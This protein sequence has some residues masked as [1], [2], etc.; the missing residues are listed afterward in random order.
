MEGQEPAVILQEDHFPEPDVRRP[1]RGCACGS[2]LACSYLFDE[3]ADQERWGGGAGGCPGVVGWPRRHRGACQCS[4]AASQSTACRPR[5]SMLFAFCVIPEYLV[6][7][8]HQVRKVSR[9]DV[10][11]IDAITTQ[12]G[13][14][15]SLR[16]LRFAT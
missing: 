2:S 16:A 7:H 10:R 9:A 1:G 15:C 5:E 12:H 3:L 11:S 6:L 8:H 13:L 14:I 4:A